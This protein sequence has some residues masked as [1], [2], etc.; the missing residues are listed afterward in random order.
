MSTLLTIPEVAASLRVS[1]RTVER[2]LSNGMLVPTKVGARTLV[3]ERA[4]S[5]YQQR[6]EGFRRRRRV[7]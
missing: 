6:Q 7:A 4:L 1:R 3:S 2:L 5:E